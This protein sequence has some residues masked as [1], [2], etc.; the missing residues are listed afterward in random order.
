MLNSTT[1]H[2][3]TNEIN[4]GAVRLF[5]K[6]GRRIRAINIA[7]ILYIQASG[8]Y[9]NIAL[10][11]GEIFHSKNKIT[12]FENRLPRNLFVRI[13]RSYILNKEYIKEIKAKQNNYEF[14]LT[15]DV[16]VVSGP[17]YRK[18]IRELFFLNLTQDGELHI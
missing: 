16:V 4:N 8:D 7:N 12:D 11:T 13:H 3:V 10:A 17:T 1:D 6:I 9:I 18:Y 5:I 2:Y 15:N 14:M